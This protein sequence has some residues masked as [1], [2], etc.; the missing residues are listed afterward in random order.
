MLRV[1][2]RLARE[3]GNK[4]VKAAPKL[5]TA[6]RRDQ[7]YLQAVEHYLRAGEACDESVVVAA[8]NAAAVFLT[9]KK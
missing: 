2:G 5:P 1:L 4:L 6:A 3:E 9:Q 8:C 7:A